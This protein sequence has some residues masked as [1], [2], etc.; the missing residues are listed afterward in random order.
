LSAFFRALMALIDYDISANGWIG[1]I[2]LHNLAPAYPLGPVTRARQA[3]AA[4]LL[5]C[6]APALTDIVH[7][8]Q[9][10]T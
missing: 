9:H 1:A 5:P 10:W 3:L 2:I 8:S 6:L 7:A 4:S